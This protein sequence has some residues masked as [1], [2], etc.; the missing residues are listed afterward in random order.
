ML[1]F[2]RTLLVILQS[3]TLAFRK[4]QVS[5]VESNPQALANK[6]TTMFQATSQQ[7]LRCIA[8]LLSNLPFNVFAPIILPP[9]YIQVFGRMEM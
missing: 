6:I 1:G 9:H 8:E 2:N 4:A 7:N 3:P 5:T